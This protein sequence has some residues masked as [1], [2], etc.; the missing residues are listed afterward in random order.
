MEKIHSLSRRNLLAA[1]AAGAVVTAASAA[2][3]AS[4]G[5]PDQPAE[6]AVNVTNPK[7]LVD[8]GPQDPDL[9]SKEPSFLSPPATDVN[10]ML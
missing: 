7:A 1:G 10:G 5:N 2:N 9:A 4:F 8:P 3:A 6:G